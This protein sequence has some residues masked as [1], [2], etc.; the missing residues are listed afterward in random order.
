VASILQVGDRWRALIRR[1][2]H[3]AQCKT[4]DTK[5]QALA[6]AR[7]REGEIDTGHTVAQP[8]KL[9]VREVIRAYRELRDQARPIND[10][11]N[12]HY[13]LKAL[14]KG[15]GEKA[16][17]RLT[18]EDLIAYAVSRREDGAGPYTINMDIS[19]LG[20]V[21]RYGGA[22]LR[23]ALP[24]AVG[25][26]RPMLHHLRLIGGGG[27]RER[28]P[29]DDEMHRILLHMT[30]TYG[31]IYAEAVAFAA[32]TAMRRGEV[33]S[34]LKAEIEPASHVI[35]VW[36]KH[37]RKGKVLERVPLLGEA[38][39]IA[40]RQP[41]SED[42]RLFPIEAGTLSKYFTW[43]CRELSIPDLHLHDMRHEGTS[44]LFEDGYEIQHVALVTGHKDW[45]NLKRYTNLRPEDMSAIKP[46]KTSRRRNVQPRPDSPQTA[47]PPQGKSSRGKT[48]R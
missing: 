24:D 43:T 17:G 28:R 13:M 47:S 31:P 30:K 23:V 21:L 41:D 29:T 18:V 22:K 15:L 25:S 20:T 34:V 27:R 5:A 6:W 36:R 37:P 42:G 40:H 45:R 3:K 44:R 38:W 8:G 1:K 11:S 32:I 12:E 16:A 39:D 9:L 33:C 26:A 7:A 48:R 35:P 46:R 14:E 4:F 19:K 10:T 2:G